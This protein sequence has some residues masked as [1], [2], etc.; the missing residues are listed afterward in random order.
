MSCLFQWFWIF[1][2]A[3]PP[4]VKSGAL[5]TF[6]ATPLPE[7]TPQ[8]SPQDELSPIIV[9]VVGAIT[10]F[11]LILTIIIFIR[12]PRTI[13]KTGQHVVQHTAEA[14]IPTITHH[15]ALP[16]KKR[17]ELSRKLVIEI[18]LILV[19]LPFFIGLLIPPIDQLTKQIII[20][21]AAVLLGFSLLC[22]VCA[23]LI[24]PATTSRTRS[25]VSRG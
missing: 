10:L 19:L 14:I 11:V 8:T 20:I 3:L 5:D 13:S 22:F 15:K 16:A 17:R 1:I 21:V 23:W 24:Q 25:H 2:I 7:P 6:I 9:L 18:Q 12:L 4:L